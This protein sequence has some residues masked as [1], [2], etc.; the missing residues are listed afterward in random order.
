M[1]LIFFGELVLATK[2]MLNYLNAQTKGGFDFLPTTG[3]QVGCSAQAKTK[4]VEWGAGEVPGQAPACLR[5]SLVTPDE[6][7]GATGHEQ[8]CGPARALCPVTTTWSQ[9]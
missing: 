6:V 5:P 1:S 3:N 2:R 4:I 8:D 9:G 7:P